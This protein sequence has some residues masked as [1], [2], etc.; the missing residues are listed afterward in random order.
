MGGLSIAVADD[1]FVETLNPAALHRIH[2]THL[3][4]QYVSDQSRYGDA[5][6]S[7][8]SAYSNFNG[9]TFAMPLGRGAGVSAGLAPWTRMDF[10]LVFDHTLD[11]ESYSKTLRAK[12]GLN[13]G[14]MSLWWGFRSLFAVGVSGHFVFGRMNESWRIRYNGADFTQTDNYLTTRGSGLSATAGVLLRPIPSVSLGAVVRPDLHIE[15]RTESVYNLASGTSAERDGRID[16]PGVLAMGAGWQVA[17]RL[18]L[19]VEWLRQQWDAFR[20]NGMAAPSINGVW[21]AAVGTEWQPVDAP[22]EPYLN[23]LAFR[24]GFSAGRMYV[25]DSRGGDVLEWMA[26]VGIGFPMAYSA[27]R[28]DVALGFGRRGNRADNGFDENVFRL[29]VSA[30]VAEKW[31]QRR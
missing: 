14:T 3:S 27:S 21:R 30:S 23:R 12:G 17:N 29:T 15:T 13:A 18:F 9:F 16:L 31:F 2:L 25:V 7:A 28:L 8:F 22:A 5:S 24:L 26:T 6:G 10:R 4:I 11:G 20:I 1:R 19:G